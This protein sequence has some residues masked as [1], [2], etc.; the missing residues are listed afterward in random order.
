MSDTPETDHLEGQLGQAAMHSHPILWEHSRRMERERDRARALAEEFHRDQVRLLMERDEA[1]EKAER[2]RLEANALMM[3]RD[4]ARDKI[5]RQADRIS[6]LFDKDQTR[7]LMERDKAREELAIARETLRLIA[8]EGGQT[9]GR[10]II[11]DG[12]WCAE[13]AR[14]AIFQESTQ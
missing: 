13:Q 14:R 1:R 7:L 10:T 5:T 9:T 4:E 3:Q 6:N 2:Y 11:P 12:A 8:E